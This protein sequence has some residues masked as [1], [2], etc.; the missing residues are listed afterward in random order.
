MDK[1]AVTTGSIALVAILAVLVGTY[2]YFGG[3]GLP[4]PL[5]VDMAYT[6][7]D[8]VVVTHTT[9]NGMHIFSGTIPMTSTCNK[10]ATGI[11][12]DE[13]KGRLKT[14]LSVV[15]L[16]TEDGACEGVANGATQSFTASF[17]PD[18]NLPVDL[19]KL[20]VNGKEVA[21]TTK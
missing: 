4:K 5:P 20:L 17:M 13:E 16:S 18:H 7:P 10:I 19:V 21:F 1:K 11:S 12:H 14:T 9:K 15:M 8:S 6:A 3:S 2:L